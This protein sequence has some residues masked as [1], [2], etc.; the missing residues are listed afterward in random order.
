MLLFFQEKMSEAP[1]ID[2][3]GT[4]TNTRVDEFFDPVFKKYCE[5]DFMKKKRILASFL[6]VFS[7]QT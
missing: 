5:I 3:A 2:V 7:A 6:F 1:V 4:F